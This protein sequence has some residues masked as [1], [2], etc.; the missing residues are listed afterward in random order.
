MGVRERQG[1]SVRLAKTCNLLEERW[2]PVLWN[3]GKYERLGIRE[4]L[5]QAGRIRQI[6]ASNPMDRLAILRFLLALLYWCKGNPPADTDVPADGQ[7]H[8]SWFAKL[9][10]H[11]DCFNLLGD[12]RRFYQEASAR[13]RRTVTDLLQEI[14]TGNNFWHFRHSTD[15]RD[16]LCPSCCAL[17]LVRLPL[18]SVTGLPNLRSGIN[19]APPVYTIPLGRSLCETL[20]ANWLPVKD[21]GTPAWVDSHARPAPGKDVPLLIGLTLLHASARTS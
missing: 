14:P 9:E 21:I 2:I 19:G 1:R 7:F 17:G 15:E 12:G 5:M 10:R 6:A 3:K 11:K 8:S 13:R 4:T 18:F 20:L 16:G